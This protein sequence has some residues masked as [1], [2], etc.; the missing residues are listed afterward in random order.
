[1]NSASLAA[2]LARARAPWYARRILV[3]LHAIDHGCLHLT[4]PNQFALTIGHGQPDAWLQCHHWSALRKVITRGD[5]GFAEGYIDGD[6]TTP[7]L[8][9]LLT[10]LAR[11]RKALDQAIY[12]RGWWGRFTARVQHLLNSNTRAGSRRNIAAHYD[13]G[14]D[15]YALWLDPGMTYS[16]ARFDGDMGRSLA[17]AQDRKYQAM[18]DLVTPPAARAPL[19]ILEI[20]CGWGGFAELATQHGHRVRGLT[21]SR[22]QL[23]YAR[24]RLDVTGR[25][26]QA[27][28]VFQDYRDET[29]QYDAIVSIEMFEAVGEKYWP[30][31]FQ[32]I[33][34]TLKPGG[35]AAI[36]SIL[37]DDALFA[38]YRRGSDFIQQYVFPGGMLP[39][40]SRL[41][42]CAAQA[43]LTLGNVSLMG[44]DYAATLARWRQAFHAQADA[45][46]ALGFDE[47]FMRIW[48]FYLAYCE[49]GFHAGSINVAQ[50][51]LQHA[52]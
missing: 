27:E 48:H 50:F 31:Y 12:G 1:M 28:F 21:L 36:Q 45:I 9:G 43:G 6:W 25:G 33:S 7:D 14:N 30:V 41:R 2:T 38:R 47:K 34:K 16:A 24:Q 39:S 4:L 3:L 13:L 23:D 19:S 20:G 22:Q 15:F 49:A 5:I 26:T 51:R 32:T 35:S 40:L 44:A 18:L 29:A 46:R 8:T 11:N 10:L 37:I 52:Q 42:E 17:A